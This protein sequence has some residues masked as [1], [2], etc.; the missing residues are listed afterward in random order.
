MPSPDEQP[1]PTRKALRWL[2][3]AALLGAGLFALVFQL[4]LPGRLP[5]EE[6]HR[7]AAAYLRDR[8][9]PGD[10]V[11]LYPWWTERARLFLPPSV[12]VV[13]YL[14]DGRDPLVDARR[15]WL[16]A[17]PD[18]PKSD[19]P[20]FL[21]RFEG[22][23][24]RL[25]GPVRFGPIELS[26]Y[27]NGLFQPERFAA[28]KALASA[29]VYLELPDRR[30][31]CRFDGRAHRCPGA[32]EHVR[33]AA[34][35]HEVFYEPRHCLWMHPPGG[36]GKLVL[37]LPAV[38]PSEELVL[39]AGVIWEWAIAREPSVTRLNLGVEEV[40][41]GRSLATLSIP[42]GLQPLQRAAVEAPTTGGVRVWIQ[43]DRADAR[44][45]CVELKGRGKRGTM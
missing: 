27:E 4:T 21:S 45:T 35:W 11:M 32:G 31:E 40:T 9:Q 17:Q 10:A 23:R 41:T 37:E 16:Y 25:E 14:D 1:T 20:D 19:L 26:L 36:P 22:A 7:Q 3:L 28:T 12:D 43:S 6:H 38:P 42:P 13:A 33:V 44:G 18:L 34:E 24:K 15:I 2:E 39:E 29:R 5:S 8:A 30:V